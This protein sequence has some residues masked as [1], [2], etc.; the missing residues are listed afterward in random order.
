ML[1][2]KTAVS[3]RFCLSS[4][5]TRVAAAAPIRRSRDLTTKVA[6]ANGLNID[7]RGANSTDARAMLGSASL[8]MQIVMPHACCSLLMIYIKASVVVK[9]PA[10]RCQAE[11]R[12]QQLQYS[13][14]L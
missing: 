9:S 2:S 4:K 1:A 14:P 3:G 8:H 5:A 11:N 10:I 13:S 6:A 7:L 12:K